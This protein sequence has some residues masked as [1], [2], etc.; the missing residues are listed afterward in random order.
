[1]TSLMC[2]PQTPART[3]QGRSQHDDSLQASSADDS[4]ER[5]IAMDDDD[6]HGEPD[7]AID[8]ASSCLLLM[9][10]HDIQ[11]IPSAVAYIIAAVSMLNGGTA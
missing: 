10:L 2:A 4:P 9:C 3:G 11:C 1:M 8:G 5:V 6:S 7:A